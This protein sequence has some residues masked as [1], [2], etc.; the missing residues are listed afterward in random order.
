MENN[1]LQHYNIK[2]SKW[3]VRRFQYKDGSLTPAGIARYRKQ[4]AATKKAQETKRKNAEAK[5]AAEKYEKDKQDALKKGSAEDVLKFKGDLSEEQIRSAIN[6]I[7][8]EQDLAALVSKP[9]PAPQ[10]QS[11]NQPN[12]NQQNNNQQA[13]PTVK[14]GETAVQKFVKDAG[15]KIFLDTAVEVA[16]QGVK[17]AMGKAIN[18]RVGA[19]AVN[20]DW[21]ASKK[22][23]KK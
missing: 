3:G 14:K 6:R 8:L 10:T 18:D 12:N 1:E 23:D 16:S 20:V 17:Y 2:G 5:A 7:K 11:N 15:K 19:K 13:N 22:D 9:T 21:K 4:K